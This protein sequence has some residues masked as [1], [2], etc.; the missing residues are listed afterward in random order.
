VS[1]CAVAAAQVAAYFSSRVPAIWLR[2]G[3][4]M[5]VLVVGLSMGYQFFRT[6]M[7]Q[8]A[9]TVGHKLV[10]D[11]GNALLGGALIGLA[12]AAYLLFHGQVAGISGFVATLLSQ[13]STGRRNAV[14]F[15]LGLLSAGFAATWIHPTGFDVP[16]ASLVQVALAGLLVG[17]GT[18]LS[19][20]CTSGHGV[21]GVSRL[22]PRSLVAT[23]T[24]IGFGMLTVAI[25]KNGGF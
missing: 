4:G 5:L 17:A 22:S 6:V 15:L 23:A 11:I 24:F 1:A 3:F 12:A 25:A 8:S 13:A 2:K 9:A 10:G 20:G 7:A 19:N 18:R 14:A 16:Q 21:C